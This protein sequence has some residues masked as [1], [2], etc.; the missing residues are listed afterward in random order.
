MKIL[1]Y[2]KEIDLQRKL[3]SHNLKL[4]ISIG[5]DNASHQPMLHARVYFPKDYSS[6][7]KNSVS[8]ENTNI[9]GG[10]HPALVLINIQLDT[11]KHGRPCLML[12]EFFVRPVVHTY[13]K[14]T[15]PSERAST[16]GLGRIC[17][18][19]ALREIAKVGP[20]LWPEKFPPGNNTEV[21]LYAEGQHYKQGKLFGSNFIG[22]IKDH[23]SLIQ[24]YKVLGFR[25][26]K[27]IPM[28]SLSLMTPMYGRISDIIKKCPK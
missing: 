4:T 17:L 14:S 16:K 26:N 12:G 23:T 11:D 22:S 6:A 27:L 2:I 15:S 20:I 24:Y 25:I 13:S 5:E 3:D 19:F 8:I 21:H 7:L 9:R 10:D 18:C 28:P 1:K